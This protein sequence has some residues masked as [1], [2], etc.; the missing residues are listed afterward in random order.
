MET[1]WEPYFWQETW[2]WA[3]EQNTSIFVQRFITNLV[4]TKKIEM[5]HIQSES[6]P[7]DA[8]SK[9]CKEAT[10][11]KHAANIYNG[12]FHPTI[13]EGVQ[14]TFYVRPYGQKRVLVMATESDGTKA[15]G[16]ETTVDSFRSNGLSTTV[17]VAVGIGAYTMRSD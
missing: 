5:E 10:H 3:R 15:D 13:G 16:I 17:E 9:N 6:N 7:A 2:Q 4:E 12:M 11:V 14:S 8:A 1:I